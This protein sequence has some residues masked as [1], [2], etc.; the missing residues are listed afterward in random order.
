MSAPKKRKPVRTENL[1]QDDTLR[2]ALFLLRLQRRVGH[3]YAMALVRRAFA[4]N[5]NTVVLRDGRVVDQ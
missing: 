2:L 5:G 4:F 3:S 1:D